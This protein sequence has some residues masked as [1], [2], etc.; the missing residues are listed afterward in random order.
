MKRTTKKVTL[1]TLDKKIDVLGQTLDKKID[2][3]GQ[4]LDKKIGDL[5]ET[6]DG[7]ARSTKHGFDAAI[8]FQKEMTEFA[9]KTA[10]TLFAVDSKLQIS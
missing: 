8:D 6:V 4:T 10:L 3:L 1:Q 9:Q 2:V 5:T 7:L